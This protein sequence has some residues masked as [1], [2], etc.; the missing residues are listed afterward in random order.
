MRIC[1]NRRIKRDIAFTRLLQA[2]LVTSPPDAH[3]EFAEDPAECIRNVAFPHGRFGDGDASPA[4]RERSMQRFAR[5]LMVVV[6]VFLLF[7]SCF[8]EH[9]V[10]FTVSDTVWAENRIHGTN[11]GISDSPVT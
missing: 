9:F 1:Q 4:R 5:F 3:P 8:M 6:S 10:C 7:L 2:I 11:A